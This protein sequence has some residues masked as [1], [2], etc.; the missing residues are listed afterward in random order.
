MNGNV[1]AVVSLKHSLPCARCRGCFGISV[2]CFEFCRFIYIFVHVKSLF[3][4]DFTQQV[5]A[6]DSVRARSLESRPSCVKRSICSIELV[7]DRWHASAE[8]YSTVH[9]N[10]D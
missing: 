6:F 5:C 3:S 7:A 8:L 10:K 4:F 9:M 1:L 2:D